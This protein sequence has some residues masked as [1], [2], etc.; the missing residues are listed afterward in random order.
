MTDNFSDSLNWKVTPLG[1]C[2]V[3][4]EKYRS[5]SGEL[6]WQVSWVRNRDNPIREA[7]V[8]NKTPYAIVGGSPTR[9]DQGEELRDI[10]R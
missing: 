1:D 4:G 6:A 3:T 10:P 5:H 8:R 7:L 2:E 9:L